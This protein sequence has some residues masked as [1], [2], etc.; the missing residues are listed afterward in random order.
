M[1]PVLQ[2][3][4]DLSITSQLMW[5]APFILLLGI[6][7]G[8][9]DNVLYLKNHN[10]KNSHFIYIYLLVVAANVA[11]WIYAPV[12]AYILFLVV[13]AY[14]FGQ[15]QVSHYFNNQPF[16]HRTLYLSWGLSVLSALIYWNH[17]EITTLTNQFS[18]F[19]AFSLVHQKDFLLYLYGTSTAYTIGVL[20]WLVRS[21]KIS[22]EHFAMEIFV[23]SLIFICFYITPLV[24]GFTLYFVILHSYKV[25]REEYGFLYSDQSV[26]SVSDFIRMVLPLTLFSFA[27]IAFLF[28]L[29]FFDILSLSYGY[30]LL[31]I[32]SSITLPHVVVMNKFYDLLFLKNY[33][34]KKQ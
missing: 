12:L 27:G 32:I 13:S 30:C 24:V 5:T 7:H 29:I 3:L 6:P 33:Y 11:I 15:S 9:I 21:T 8:A 19:T 26:H 16:I 22:L 23:L 2:S 4:Q 34:T 1:L 17:L 25:L 14:H 18:D 20:L 10:V 28:S 31:I